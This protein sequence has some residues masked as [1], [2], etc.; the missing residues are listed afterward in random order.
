LVAEFDQRLSAP[1]AY[2]LLS[3]PRFDPRFALK[4]GFM[5]LIAQGVLRLETE[6]RPG[7]VR[8][9][10]IPH[11]R[12]ADG[13]PDNLPPVAASL[14]KIARAAE[15]DGLIKDVLRHAGRE[16]GRTLMGF[17][18]NCLG[19]ALATRDLAEPY[20]PRFLGLAPF[21]SFRR[22]PAGDTEKARLEGLISDATSIPDYLDRD[23]A[24]VAALV[25][26][27]GGAILLVD[28]LRPH[29]GA[30]ARAMRDRD[31]GGTYFDNPSGDP[32]HHGDAICELGFVDFGCFDSAAFDSFDAGF[33]DAA[34][35]GT[36]GC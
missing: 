20:R 17:M 16:Y 24:R 22:T 12:G 27:L 19:P 26:A 7:L 2:L 32:G 15:P 31:A 4:I 8:T 14:V 33:S 29:Y 18:Q 6:D 10:H 23:P 35:G 21:D 3:L 9:R 1:E 36:S 25:A 5:G 11:L 34:D 28:K 13:V 30:L